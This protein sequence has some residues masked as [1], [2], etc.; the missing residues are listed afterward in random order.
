[1]DSR[2]EIANMTDKMTQWIVDHM[3][4]QELISLA[5]EIVS[6]NIGELPDEEIRAQYAS[7]LSATN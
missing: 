1:M 4:Q 7:M 6:G 5:Y 3:D 2:E